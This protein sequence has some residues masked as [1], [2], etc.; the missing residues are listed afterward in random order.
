MSLRTVAESWGGKQ[1]EQYIQ[2]IG[3][4]LNRPQLLPKSMEGVCA[5]LSLIWLAS[6]KANLTSEIFSTAKK[7]TSSLFK[8]AERASLLGGDLSKGMAAFDNTARAL[9]LNDMG[10]ILINNRNIGRQ[11][12][13]GP[14]SYVLIMV[15]GH[16]AAVKLMP[17]TAIFFEPNAGIFTFPSTTS[18][19]FFLEDYLKE[20]KRFAKRLKFYN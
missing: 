3:L 7:Y 20:V 1:T 6:Y 2:Q 17:P 13:N 14:S 19:E 10:T 12:V 11:V 16:A 5:G 15:S 4:R 18:I 9:S 8:Y